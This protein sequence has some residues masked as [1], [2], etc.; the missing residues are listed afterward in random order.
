MDKSIHEFEVNPLGESFKKIEKC[1]FCEGKVM[2][3]GVRKKKMESV[4]IYFC[5]NCQKRFTSQITKNKTYPL[6]VIIEALTLY[7]RLYK[8]EEISK[9][10]EE[11]YSIKL[12]PQIISR[13][14]EEI[15]E[16][17]FGGK[18]EDDSRTIIQ[19]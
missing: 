19:F 2:K 7:N 4:Q 8:F 1:P 5:K 17:R 14:L 13:W 11:K 12:S 3:R 10:I 18:C 15:F 9:A 6:R 16:K